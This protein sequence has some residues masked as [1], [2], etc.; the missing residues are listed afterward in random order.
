MKKDE[1][2]PKRR[3]SRRKRLL[4]RYTALFLASFVVCLGC[5]GTSIRILLDELRNAETNR[6]VQSLMS[7]SAQAEGARD[8]AILFNESASIESGALNS[9]FSELYAANSDLVGWI[10]AGADIDL[11]VVQA[12]DNSTYLTTD[13]YGEYN[14]AGSIFMDAEN[15]ISPADDHIVIYGH[16]M[17]SGTMFGKLP[18][19]RTLSY[20]KQYP[21]LQYRTIYDSAEEGFCVP[22]AIF[23]ASM[24][25]GDASYF[26]LRRFNFDSNEEKLAF[27]QELKDRSIFD[28]P[29][30][31][32][33]E[34]EIVSF[35]TCSYAND[36][37][38]FIIA[39]RRLRE[40]ESTQ[41]LGE[42]VQQ[43]AAKT[44]AA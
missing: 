16:N 1:R 2:T 22:F 37:G 23:D 44:S 20:L 13:F 31:V 25:K 24:E 33:A 26:Q 43:A 21:L 3:I 27:I 14:R 15:V 34:D 35:V 19:Y 30:D 8:G 41:A 11:P 42:Q 4:K 10:K 36:N 17:K 6:S 32:N 40:G 9:D 5:A 38:R 39:M 28:I 7:A 12:G 18:S 29:V